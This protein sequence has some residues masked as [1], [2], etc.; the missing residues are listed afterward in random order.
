MQIKKGATPLE[1]RAIDANLDRLGLK[2]NLT[3]GID[4]ASIS[5]SRVKGGAEALEAAAEGG[6]LGLR[7]L[8]ALRTKLGMHS[9]IGDGSAQ[10]Q[11]SIKSAGLALQGAGAEASSLL[12]R[13]GQAE[14]MQ[15][16]DELAKLSGRLKQAAAQLEQAIEPKTLAHAGPEDVQLLLTAYQDFLSAWGSINLGVA[17]AMKNFD[18][19]DFSHIIALEALL[20]ASKAA[21]QPAASAPKSGSFSDLSAA[22]LAESAARLLQAAPL[23]QVG[24]SHLTTKS[25]PEVTDGLAAKLQA[26]AMDK[27]LVGG[28]HLLTLSQMEGYA[29]QQGL[30][31]DQVMAAVTAIRDGHDIH[32]RLGRWAAE[33]GKSFGRFFFTLS[34]MEQAGKDIG[35]STLAVMDALDL[36][37][38]ISTKNAK[39]RG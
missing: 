10:A 31:L 3:S 25:G 5:G 38:R 16:L 2:R 11:A 27:E 37:D 14:P 8:Q 23:F 18:A 36:A 15:V 20:G 17:A 33:S 1:Q 34:E 30:G 35:A 7:G 6:A 4:S 28:A 26:W 22:A 21:A 24:H 13:I 32:G 19:L 39:V 9:F 29:A 12:G